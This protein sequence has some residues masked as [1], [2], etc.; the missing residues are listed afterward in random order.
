MPDGAE[1]PPA[2]GAGKRM[3]LHVHDRCAHVHSCVFRLCVHTLRRWGPGGRGGVT[4][5]Q[6][7]TVHRLTVGVALPHTISP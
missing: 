2:L 3:R 6:R 4:W 7:L 1:G 5:L